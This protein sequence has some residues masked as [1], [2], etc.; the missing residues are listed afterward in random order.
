MEN[1]NLAKKICNFGI[2][3]PFDTA[4]YSQFRQFSYSSFD[5]NQFSQFL[6]PK[7]KA[8]EI[9]KFYCLK[10]YPSPILYI[11][12]WG[13]ISWVSKRPDKCKCFQLIKMKKFCVWQPTW[14]FPL[15]KRLEVLVNIFLPFFKNPLPSLSL[16]A[17]RVYTRIQIYT[18]RK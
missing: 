18:N 1:H 17:L 11:K 9:L 15:I 2:L 13:V 16:W 3:R 8:S 12:N 5:I 6:F 7:F 4:H 10:F 14:S